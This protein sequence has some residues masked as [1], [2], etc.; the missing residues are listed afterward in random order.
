MS[1]DHTR[2]TSDDLFELARTMPRGEELMSIEETAA[3]LGVS[4]RTVRRRQA[5]GKM[6]RRYHIGRQDK[7]VRAHIEALV[8][9]GGVR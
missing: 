5:A 7:Y 2:L 8:R 3:A 9:H 1:P 6:S 4:I